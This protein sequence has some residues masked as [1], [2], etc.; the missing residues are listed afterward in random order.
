LIVARD[1]DENDKIERICRLTELPDVSVPW[2]NVSAR[3]VSIKSDVS[4][5]N[6]KRMPKIHLFYLRDATGPIA[7]GLGDPDGSDLQFSASAVVRFSRLRGDGL[8]AVAVSGGGINTV[9]ETAAAVEEE[10]DN[11]RISSASQ[12]KERPKPASERT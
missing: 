5:H 3:D 2:S 9:I 1:G 8:A 7:I 12:K 6:T 4:T 10:L 11:C